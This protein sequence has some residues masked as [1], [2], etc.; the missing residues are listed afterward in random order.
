MREVQSPA[1]KTDPDILSFA[2]LGSLVTA[3]G[4]Y[5]LEAERC[6]NAGAHLAKCIMLAATIGGQLVICVSSFP[7][8]AERALK[9]LQESNEI[10]RGLKLSSVLEWDLGQLL[11]VA[12]EAQWLPPKVK[13]YPFP[14]VDTAEVLSADHIREL[15]N[16]VHP[17][18]LVRERKGQMITKEELDLLYE[19]CLGV[20]LHLE[21]KLAPKTSIE[22]GA[23]IESNSGRSE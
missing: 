23:V 10:N 2:E 1:L 13:R 5:G 18:R 9:R 7:E 11:K 6:A 12:R 14:A 19:T 22:R 4:N 17:G 20:S 16:L 15:R 8:E 3:M 21:Q